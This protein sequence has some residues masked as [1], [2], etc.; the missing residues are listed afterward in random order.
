LRKEFCVNIKKRI[1]REVRNILITFGGRDY[2]SFFAR[3]TDTLLNYP[4]RL[5]IVVPAISKLH[6]PNNEKIRIYRALT[7]I[8]MRSLML[9]ADLCI[10]AGG[11]T[12]YELAAMAVPIIGICFADNQKLNLKCFKKQR[13]IEFAGW[14]TDKNIV[15]KLNRAVLKLLPYKVRKQRSKIGKKII[16]GMG[17][18]RLAE[19]LIGRGKSKIKLSP[20]EKTDC[21]ELLRWRNH[22]LVRRWCFNAKRIDLKT[23]RKWFYSSLGNSAAKIYIAK[24]GTEKVGVIRF[25]DTAAAGVLTNINLNPDFLHRGLGTEIIKLGT[26]KILKTFKKPKAVIAKIKNDNY[27]SQKA[28]R[29]AGYVLSR[30][31]PADR[32]SLTM[33]YNRYL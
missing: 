9:K 17:T 25:A 20:A 32:N 19:F 22:P 11:Q 18:H 29:K 16:D 8:Q 14:H 30:E 13:F 3:I 7:A 26:E 6:L 27:I 1:N 31:L 23:H 24:Q 15:E 21:I 5:H 28:F 2:S 33:V 12:L 10:S 4:F